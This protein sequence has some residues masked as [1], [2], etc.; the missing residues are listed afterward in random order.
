MPRKLRFFIFLSLSIFCLLFALYL[1]LGQMDE[2]NASRTV[3]PAGTTIAGIPVGGLD[4]RAAGLRLVQA[5][6]LTPLELRVD[7]MVAQI[8]PSDA[9]LELDLQGMLAAGQAQSQRSYWSGFWDF[10]MNRPLA[11]VSADLFCSVSGE[12]L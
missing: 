11:P 3:Y 4:A 2:Y 1:T 12:R 10:L 9:G 8:N 5:Y 7:G 6:S